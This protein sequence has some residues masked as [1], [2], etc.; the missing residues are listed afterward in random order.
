V[1]TVVYRDGVMAGDGRE[2]IDQGGSSMI[3]RDD[4]PKVYRLK[5]GRVFGAA[6]GSEAIERMLRAL[7]EGQDIHKLTPHLE[8]VVAIVVDK[9]GRIMV[10]EGI[11]WVRVRVPFYTIGSGSMFAFP[12]LKAGVSAIEAVRIAC[13][14]D[15]FSGGK[16][17][18]IVV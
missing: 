1:T 8:D 13:E 15:P 7:N 14:C 18:H 11:I 6:H 5:D 2:T 17:S 3:L 4:C 12:A 10:S 16:K 9:K